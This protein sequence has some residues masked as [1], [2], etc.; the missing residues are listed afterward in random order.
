M[1]HVNLLKAATSQFGLPLGFIP[2][3]DFDNGNMLASLLGVLFVWLVVLGCL[4]VS[5]CL[6]LDGTHFH[7]V[8]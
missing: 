7:G 6:F 1:K 5:V 4:H 3:G 8:V 2:R